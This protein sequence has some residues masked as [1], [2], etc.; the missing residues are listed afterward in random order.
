MLSW[1]EALEQRISDIE[2]VQ[3][4]MEEQLADAFAH[5]GGGNMVLGAFLNWVYAEQDRALIEFTRDAEMPK[6]E[7]VATL[8]TFSRVANMIQGLSPNK[9]KLEYARR[10]SLKHFGT[11]SSE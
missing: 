8:D 7:L 6:G 9:E 2:S 11:G 1:R 10:N 3:T 4:L 5:T